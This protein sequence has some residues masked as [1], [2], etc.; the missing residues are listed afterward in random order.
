MASHYLLF[1]NYGPPN[2]FETVGR[3]PSGLIGVGRDSVQEAQRMVGDLS[4]TPYEIV[5]GARGRLEVS[6]LQA[7]QTAR[8]EARRPFQVRSTEPLLMRLRGITQRW[9]APSRLFQRITG[10]RLP[11]TSLSEWNSMFGDAAS[12]IRSNWITKRYFNMLYEKYPLEIEEIAKAVVPLTNRG[13]KSLSTDEI[14]DIWKYV[15]EEALVSPERAEGTK[16]I[17]QIVSHKKAMKEVQDLMSRDAVTDT[18]IKESIFNELNQGRGWN[19]I[20]DL[21]DRALVD[22][23]VGNITKLEYFRVRFDEMVNEWKAIMAPMDWSRVKFINLT[24]EQQIE[25]KNLIDRLP[26]NLRANIREIEFDP[27]VDFLGA[28]DFN[29]NRIILSSI[30]TAPSETYWEDAKT[31][32]HE[33]GHNLYEDI[34]VFDPTT[35]EPKNPKL[36]D[37]IYNLTTPDLRR[38]YPDDPEGEAFADAFMYHVTDDPNL[39]KELPG[40]DLFMDKYFLKPQPITRGGRPSP[41]L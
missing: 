16:S 31:L 38:K 36:Y 25:I 35:G 13:I 32:Y 39:P 29:K 20:D 34:H 24:D 41:L 14:R 37:E 27:N 30:P 4:N 6:P 21:M 22:S 5:R 9:E 40:W 7:A 28:F 12:K 18:A 19:K 8:M 2:L 26:G 15:Y 11:I 33:I 1:M 3:A 10:K 17:L 23:D